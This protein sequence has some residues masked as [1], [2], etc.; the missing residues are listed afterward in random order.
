MGGEKN[1]HAIV[2]ELIT[3]I[4]ELQKDNK[5][6]EYDLDELTDHDDPY[7]ESEYYNWEEDET[8]PVGE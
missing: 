8:L 4:E 2:P 6:L 1:V 7:Y 3:Y 5:R